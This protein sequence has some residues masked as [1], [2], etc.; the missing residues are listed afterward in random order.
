MFKHFVF[1]D[2]NNV[3][4]LSFT[5]ISFKNQYFELK[6]LKIYCSFYKVEFRKIAKNQH[7]NKHFCNLNDFLVC[8]WVKVSHTKI[9]KVLPQSVSC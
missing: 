9:H 8:S 5:N 4:Y 1:Y 6:F 3:L 2:N 7:S